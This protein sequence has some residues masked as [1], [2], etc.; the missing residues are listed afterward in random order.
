MY[1]DFC[2]SFNSFQVYKIRFMFYIAMITDINLSFQSTLLINLVYISVRLLSN[3][4]VHNF[5]EIVK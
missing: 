3:T 5:V 1:H 4:Y 2:V